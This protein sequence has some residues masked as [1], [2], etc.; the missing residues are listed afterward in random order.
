MT[1]LSNSKRSLKRKRSKRSSALLA[2][3]VAGSLVTGSDVSGQTANESTF[4]GMDF[5]DTLTDSTALPV[6]TTDVSGELQFGDDDFVGFGNLA[7]GT[8]FTLEF[9]NPELDG[10]GFTLVDFSANSSDGTSLDSG[11]AFSGNTGTLMGTIPLDGTLIAG[12][13]LAEGGNSSYTYSLNA[14]TAVPEPS[15]LGLLAAVAG[16]GA[17]VRR[18]KKTNK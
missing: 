17:A 5:G 9:S 12:A 15:T 3:A 14:T 11:S 1:K 8:P 18:R 4:P 7:P 6:P 13:S 10:P 2:A 16:A